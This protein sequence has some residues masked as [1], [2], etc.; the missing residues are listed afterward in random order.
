[1][2][3]MPVKGRITK[4]ESLSISFEVIL[5]VEGGFNSLDT[6]LTPSGKLAAFCVFAEHNGFYGDRLKSFS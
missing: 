1:M 5:E 2:P 3:V 4:F 6:V